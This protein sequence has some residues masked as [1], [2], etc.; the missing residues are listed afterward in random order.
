MLFTR[1][2]ILKGCLPLRS[3]SPFELGRL[4]IANVYIPRGSY[5]WSMNLA[6]K[7]KVGYFMTDSNNQPHLVWY[8]KN[9]TVSFEGKFTHDSRNK[10]LDKSNIPLG[11][12]GQDNSESYANMHT[13]Y[14][15]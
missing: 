4:V 11:H 14:I 10:V 8:G 6:L 5:K 1:K 9:G 7:R 15:Y 3:W 2:S 12:I 13:L